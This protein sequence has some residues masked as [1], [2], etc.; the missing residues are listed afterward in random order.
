MLDRIKIILSKE[1]MPKIDMFA[2]L[3]INLINPLMFIGKNDTPY[4][5]ATLKSLEVRITETHLIIDGSPATYMYG[6]NA[7]EI[8][9]DDFCTFVEELNNAFPVDIRLGRISSIEIGRNLAMNDD[10]YEY[11]KVFDSYRNA[12]IE[13]YLTTKYFIQSNKVFIIYDKNTELI[14][15]GK[16]RYV[17]DKN[18]LRIEMKLKREILK[19]LK[20]SS[21]TLNDLESKLMWEYLYQCFLDEIYRFQ[22]RKII[23][24]VI[25]S[26]KLSDFAYYTLISLADNKYPSRNLFM[27]NYFED[28]KIFSTSK[29]AALKQQMKRL[30]NNPRYVMDDPKEIEIKDKLADLTFM[31]LNNVS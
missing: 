1:D 12:K 6:H 2:E 27:M 8:T 24:P 18:I 9:Y 11:L 26:T 13:S 28:N 16:K 25:D 22:F 21:L 30:F 14:D 20:L 15:H 3:T 7:K 23:K 17:N 29:K 5:K 10:P 4:I 31:K 19:S